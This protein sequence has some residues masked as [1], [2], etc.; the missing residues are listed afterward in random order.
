MG[1]TGVG[2]I[3][4]QFAIQCALSVGKLYSLEALSG[5]ISTIGAGEVLGTF[6]FSGILW[7]IGAKSAAKNF[8]RIGQ[9]EASFIKYAKRDISRYGDPIIETIAKRGKKYINVFVLD[10]AKEEAL[11]EAVSLIFGIPSY[12]LVK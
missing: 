9:I 10:T 4:G 8:K 1:F 3:V 12:Y 5:D 2:G 7:A 11:S 6:A